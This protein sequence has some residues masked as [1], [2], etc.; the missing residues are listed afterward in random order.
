MGNFQ[1]GMHVHLVGIG[2][3]GLSAVAQVLLGRGF[4]VSGSDRQLNEMTSR[5]EDNGATIYAGHASDQIDGADL[6]LVSSAIP[7]QNP[8]V[9]A[10]NRA[11]I[12]VLKRNDFLAKLMKGSYGIAVA[13]THG[14]TT[15]TGMIAQILLEAGMD[16]TVI[17]GADLPV[18]GGNGRAGQSD[19]FVIEADEYDY[20]F[21]GL[22]PNLAIVTNV[23]YD[24]PD[25]FANP[26]AY[27]AAFVEFVERIQRD[28]H[29]I[30]C[31]DDPGA[32][33]LADRAET[34]QFDVVTYGL[35]KGDWQAVDLRPNQL[36]GSDFL[37][38]HAGKVIGLAR[39][40]V[41]GRHNVQNATAAVAAAT[42][43][44]V[45]FDKIRTALG[46][47]G[48]LG[49]RFQ[50]LGEAG[51]VVIIDD[52]AH[53]PTEIR[54]TLEAARQCFPRRRIWAVW[55]PHTFSRTKALL[56]EFASCFQQADRVIALDIYR[57]REQDTLGIDTAQV[58]HEFTNAQV[59]YVGDIVEATNYLF[60]RILPGDVVITLSAGD[61]NQVGELLLKQLRQRHTV[62]SGSSARQGG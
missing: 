55:Q 28:G 17:V 62:G 59:N 41:P 45:G 4:R 5:L 12:P 56:G 57:S 30:A 40:R 44:G 16:P 60:E 31:A 13:G 43:L 53:H 14:K 21:L 38:Q 50:V 58:V 1:P 46:A 15:T 37:V 20:M 54:A 24:H 9:Q 39:L 2:G 22:R 33:V 61:G 32:V 52:Y 3:T 23:E 36:G 47:F 25:L 29:L 35:S 18:L 51:D 19:Y 6:L 11:G 10:A 34:L 27:R 8:E 42:I 26:S 7:S 49:R 48:G